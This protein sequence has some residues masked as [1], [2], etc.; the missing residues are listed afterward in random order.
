MKWM[1]SRWFYPDNGSV[2]EYFQD[3]TFK[4]CQINK[5]YLVLKVSNLKKKDT[6]FVQTLIQGSLTLFVG[7]ILGVGRSNDPNWTAQR[8]GL[9]L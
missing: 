6:M 4:V 3:F 2:C 1:D 8:A 7:G 5:K 9:A